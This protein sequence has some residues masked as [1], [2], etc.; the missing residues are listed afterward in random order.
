MQQKCE[1][2]PS[3]YGKKMGH[4][5]KN[6][7][8]T[9]KNGP[10]YFSVM[11][12]NSCSGSMVSGPLLSGSL[13]VLVKNTGF[14]GAPRFS[15]LES[16]GAMPGS[17]HLINTLECCLYIPKSE[18]HL[19][20]KITWPSFTFLLHFYLGVF[21][22]SLPYSSARQCWAVVVL[23]WGFSVCLGSLVGGARGGSRFCEVWSL[24]N[25]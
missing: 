4:P 7:R 22:S 6:N 13:L 9:G 5:V 23:H 2:R 17:L 11:D 18:S 25:I 19:H 20:W 14:W 16:F 8:S 21:I 15:T 3:I 24:N 1:R 12:L 10:G